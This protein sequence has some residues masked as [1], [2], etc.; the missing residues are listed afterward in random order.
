LFPQFLR[1]WADA[2]RSSRDAVPPRDRPMTTQL[3]T[4]LLRAQGSRRARSVRLATLLAAWI[5]SRAWRLCQAP[6]LPTGLALQS[7]V[8]DPVGSNPVAFAFLPDGSILIIEKAPGRGRLAAVGA[9]T[10]AL[11]ATVAG[12]NGGGERGRLGVAVDPA[13]PARPFLSYLDTHTDST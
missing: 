13:W 5:G 8:T 3:R 6:T 1:S 9:R 2:P 12:V 4:G 11:I 7:G 10:S